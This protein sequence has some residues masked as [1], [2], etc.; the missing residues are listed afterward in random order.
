[1]FVDEAKIAAEL[2]HPNIV[3]IYDFGKKDN[4]YFIAMEYVEGKDLRLILNKLAEKNSHLEEH[5]AIHLII[6]TLEALSYAHSAKDSKGNNLDIVHRDISPPNILVSYSGEVKLTD[7]GVSKASNKS[8]QTLSGA[9]K[10]KLLYMSPEQAKAEKNIDNRSDIYSVGVILFELI[11]GKKLFSGSSEMAVLNKVQ[12]GKIIKP[13][14]IKPDIDPDLE[15]I[16]LRAV[17]L[18]ISKRYRNA[19]EMITALE[20]Y[21]YINFNHVPTPVHLQHRI[22][23]LFKDE[24]LKSGII[25]NQKP[26]PYEIEKIVTPQTVES[27]EDSVEKFPE[28]IEEPKDVIELSEDSQIIEHEELSEPD[29]EAPRLE[30]ELSGPEPEYLDENI[31]GTLEAESQPDATLIS[32][33]PES[34]LDELIIS[35]SRFE[36]KNKTRPVFKILLLVSLVVFSIWYLFIK[37]NGLFTP[38]E[39]IVND[40][41]EA[42]DK[43]QQKIITP[44]I[45]KVESGEGIETDGSVNP[46]IKEGV[47]GSTGIVQNGPVTVEKPVTAAE[48]LKKKNDEE[49]KRLE[50][51]KKLM[52]D[53]ELEKE[54]KRLQKIEADKRRKKAAEDKKKKEE[55]D[56]KQKEEE[57]LKLKAEEERLRKAKEEEDR[58]ALELQK[59]KEEM[60]KNRIKTG[61]L[62][63]LIEVDVKPVAVSTPSP[64]LTRSQTL[65]QSVIVMALID[66]NGNVEKVRMLRKSRSK[67]IDSV[68][69]QAIM[70]WKYKPAEKDGVKVKVWKTINLQ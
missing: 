6:K 64:K 12:E 32:T 33:E 10:G 39:N 38:S 63:S 62:V 8:H 18:D 25:V 22:Y 55:E 27:I 44:P 69:S 34:D 5:L 41:R 52:Q 20:N 28:P 37:E 57:E 31:A 45:N 23:N 53:E 35:D 19:T 54:K 14:E 61:Q 68:I 50:E 49:N 3:Q 24:I 7:F 60:E 13:S 1:M 30:E 65:R 11:T 2:T 46:E 36:K 70:N 40:G 21:L 67:K 26:E 29:F 16:I 47:D 42:V 59:K 4:F 51:E 58:K 15:N 56:L 17:T 66:H 9:L 43:S 48:E